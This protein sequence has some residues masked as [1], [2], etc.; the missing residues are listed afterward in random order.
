MTYDRYPLKPLEWWQCEKPD[1]YEQ[2]EQDTRVVVS[3]G[4]PSRAAKKKFRQYVLRRKHRWGSYYDVL[5]DEE[6]LPNFDPQ[7][8][9]T[10]YKLYGPK[11]PDGTN[12]LLT[13]IVKIFD[14]PK[15]RGGFLWVKQIRAKMRR[16]G[17]LQ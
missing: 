6:T 14:H 17:L 7:K 5:H 8:V 9:R 11:L 3:M 2:W 12:T 1:P 4:A 13:E 10:V 16:A 15:Q